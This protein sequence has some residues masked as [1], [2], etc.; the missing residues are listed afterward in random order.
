MLLD[1]FTII[2]QIVNFLILIL[3]LR[4]FLYGPIIHAMDEREQRITLRLREAQRSQAEA[5]QAEADYRQLTEDLKGDRERLIH[6]AKAEA[7]DLRKEMLREARHEV[8]QAQAAWY[9]AIQQEKES[10]LSDLH[11]RA[12]SQ[13]CAIARQALAD[14][15]NASL[16]KHII[17]VFLQRIREMAP[18]EMARISQSVHTSNGEFTIRSAFEIPQELWSEIEETVRE[19]FSID[20][21]LGY[22]VEPG[23]ICGIEL[24][25]QGQKVAWSLASYLESLEQNLSEAIRDRQR[26]DGRRS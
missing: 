5:E 18:A 12:S 26:E 10:F 25:S 15:A 20:S 11:H 24:K 17:E 4:R 8:D 13:T 19:Q 16:E 23:L 21:E 9:R 3:L 6:E 7:D 14:L 22:E 2:A 1:W